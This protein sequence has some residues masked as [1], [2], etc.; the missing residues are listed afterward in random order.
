MIVDEGGV[1][2][3][4]RAICQQQQ[5]VLRDTKTLK[6]GVGN[7][8]RCAVDCKQGGIQVTSTVVI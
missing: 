4:D 5:G 6:S 1:M 7:D 2:H 3:A 8:H